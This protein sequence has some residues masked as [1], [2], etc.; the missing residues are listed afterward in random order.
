MI[1]RVSVRLCARNSKGRVP[2]VAQRDSTNLVTE[3]LNPAEC[4][5]LFFLLHPI[6]RASLNRSFVDVQQYTDCNTTN[7]PIKLA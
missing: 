2:V 7:F 1:N 6:S 5:A 4:W 3:G